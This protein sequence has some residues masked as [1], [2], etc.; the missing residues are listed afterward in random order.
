MERFRRIAYPILITSVIGT[1]LLLMAYSPVI[2]QE[3]NPLPL[4]TS[5]VKLQFT[6][7]D[8]VQFSKSDKRS[9]Y[10]SE[11]TGNSEYEIVKEFMDSKGWKYQ[12]QMGSGLI[13]TKNGEDA[14]VEVR[15]YSKHYFIWEIQKAFFQ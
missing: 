8:F 7:N 4:L 1:S 5:A 14:V 10:L 9:R 15:Q 2:F 6:D 11:S 3:G 12:E 13:F